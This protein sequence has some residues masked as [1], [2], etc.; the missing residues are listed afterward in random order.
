MLL[1]K[2]QNLNIWKWLPTVTLLT[3][4]CAARWH[5]HWFIFWVLLFSRF[6]RCAVWDGFSVLS[7]CSEVLSAAGRPNK[8][9]VGNGSNTDRYKKKLQQSPSQTCG[10]DRDIPTVI[11]SDCYWFVQCW[12]Q[13]FYNTGRNLCLTQNLIQSCNHLYIYLSAVHTKEWWSN[14][15]RVEMWDR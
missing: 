3:G 5:H 1:K 10:L 14:W 6:Q 13:Y 2:T 8:Q 4:P 11:F 15:T 9:R 7:E 12:S